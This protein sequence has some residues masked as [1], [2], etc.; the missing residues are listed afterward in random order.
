M[1]SQIINKLSLIGFVLLFGASTAPARG[2]DEAKVSKPFQY[3]GYT[4]PEYKSLKKWSQYVEMSDG[5]KIAIDVFVPTEGPERDGFPVILHYTPY[6]RAQIDIKTGEVFD[7]ST[8]SEVRFL[9]SFGYAVVAADMRG[10]GASTGWIHDFMREIWSDGKELVDWMAE[11]DWC[12]G[13][14]GMMGGS[15]VAWSQTAT[16]SQ[17]PEALKCIMPSVIPLEGYTGEI[18]PGGIFLQRFINTWSGFMYPSQRNYVGPGRRPTKPAV[19]EDGDGDLADEIPLDKNGN[20]NFLDDGF[21]PTYSDDSPREHIYYLAT[22]EHDEGNIDYASWAVD[23]FFIDAKSPHGYSSYDIGPNAHLRGMIESGIPVYHLGGW[24]DGFARGSFELYCTMERTNPVKLA[25]FPGYH[26]QLGGPFAK[27]LEIDLQKQSQTYML[28]HVRF[29]DHYLKGI[30]NGIDREPPIHIYVMNGEG[31][32]AEPKWPLDRAVSKRLYFGAQHTLSSQRPDEQ[33]STEHT[34]DFSHDTLYGKS[35]SNRWMSVAGS[36]PVALPIRNEVD[37]KTLLFTSEP[38]EED[39][40]VTGHPIVKL[41]V[42]STADYGDFFVYLEDV[43]EKG[44]SLMVSEAQLRAGFAQLYDNDEIIF[45]GST[46]IDVKPE[47]PWHGYEKNQYVDGALAG[48]KPLE[49]VIDFHPTSWVFKPGHRVQLSIACSDFPT[50]R[51]HPKLSPSNKP[52][53]SDNIVPTITVYH[54]GEHAS[55]IELPVVPSS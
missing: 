55:S 31:W 12:D 17:K 37:K 11:Q 9:T 41:W 34:A 10:T 2:D 39:T 23:M 1:R 29:Y 13:N 24:M 14:V 30:D 48:G 44:E 54:G 8:R 18:Y 42:S 16:A 5:T 19:D 38:F 40:E 35:R 27:M 50:F 43:D 45:S 15:Y 22:K 21:P 47:L 36:T 25:M 32:R 33:G 28:E 3:S 7:G 6:Q 52:D 4:K 49:L 51:L 53:A 26:S 46:G 20:G